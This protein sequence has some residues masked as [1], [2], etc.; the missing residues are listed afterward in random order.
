MRLLNTYY[1][2]NTDNPKTQKAV[3]PENRDPQMAHRLGS[4]GNWTEIRNTCRKRGDR[5]EGRVEAQRETASGDSFLLPST[6]NLRCWGMKED[7]TE[8]N[9]MGTN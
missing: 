8:P 1:I 4:K 9:S 7:G 3:P 5:G 2:P 6:M